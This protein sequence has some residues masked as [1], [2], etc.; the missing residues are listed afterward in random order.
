MTTEK[1]LQRFNFQDRPQRDDQRAG[2][3]AL[4]LDRDGVTTPPVSGADGFAFFK[5]PPVVAPAVMWRAPTIT[6][7]APSVATINPLPSAGGIGIADMEQLEAVNV[8]GQR[9]MNLFIRFWAMSDSAPEAQLILILFAA[10][11]LPQQEVLPDG[12]KKL[13]VP[14][15]I[16]EPTIRGTDAAPSS[17]NPPAAGYRN[18]YQSQINLR[19]DPAASFNP[20]TPINQLVLTVD[21]APYTEVRLALAA[22]PSSIEATAGIHYELVR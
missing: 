11:A 8:V 7:D 20:T 22:G 19:G 9:A 13:W 4:Y 15:G 6:V 1:E 21:V 16:I 2:A 12:E 10:C 3:L 14:V 18:A 5:D 17:I